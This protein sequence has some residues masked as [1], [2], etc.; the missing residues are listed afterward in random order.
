M[1]DTVCTR[2]VKCEIYIYSE[3]I[4][5][6]GNAGQRRNMYVGYIEYRNVIFQETVLE[7]S[8]LYVG[9]RW[10]WLDGC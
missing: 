1:N 8:F 9:G 7:G 6:A 3:V 2:G 10:L 4:W 5:N